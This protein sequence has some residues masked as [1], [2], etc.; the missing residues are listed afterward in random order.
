ME[1]FN[2]SRTCSR[3]WYLVIETLTDA[4]LFLLM[5]TLVST[6][7]NYVL[8]LAF[9]SQVRAT[10]SGDPLAKL[11]VLGSAT[12]LLWVAGTFALGSFSFA[13]SLYGMLQ[14]AQHRSV[15]VVDCLRVGIMKLVPV[16]GLT[17]LWYLAAVV[18]TILLVIPAIV[19]TLMWSTSLPALINENLGIIRSF[20]RSRALTKGSRG[21]IF[22]LLL[23]CLIV[24]YGGMFAVLG[25]LAGT[26]MTGL[27]VAIR[28]QPVLYVAQ[29]PLAWAA[30]SAVNALLASIYL[31]TLAIKGGSPAGHLDQVFA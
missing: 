2:I 7:L 21:R 15:S 6:G 4:G 1:S 31:E 8:G 11:K 22:L 29:I 26:N 20:G 18:G 5:V 16:L 25:L 19:L 14:H 17:T 24:V 23:L 3:A 27:A 12:Y 10:A 13:G 28:N 9:E 30:T